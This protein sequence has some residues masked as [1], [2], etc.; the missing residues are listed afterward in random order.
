MFVTRDG[1]ILVNEIAPR[2]HNSGHH[3]I[4]ANFTSQYEQHLRA[5]MDLPLGDTSTIMN[6]AMVNLLGE[7]GYS[8][9]AHLQGFEEVLAIPGIYVHLYGKILTR[10]FRKMGHVTILEKDMAALKKKANF[11]KQTL[12]VI[13]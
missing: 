11:V 4:E 6:S 12:K 8:G 9:T 1:N 13:A 3:T 5:I 7:P 2:P 10:P